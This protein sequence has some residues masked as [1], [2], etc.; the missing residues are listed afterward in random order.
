MN[1]IVSVLQHRWL[2]PVS[3]VY[4]VACIVF[5]H[6]TASELNPIEREISYYLDSDW[7]GLATTTFFALSLSLASSAVCLRATR[8]NK[9]MKLAARFVHE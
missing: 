9:P 8:C 1:D 6:F 2:V 3:I 5:L 4:Y 7:R